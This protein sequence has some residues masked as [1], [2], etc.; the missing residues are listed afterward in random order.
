MPDTREPTLA[1]GMKLEKK[2]DNTGIPQS[3]MR[4]GEH[5]QRVVLTASAQIC[6]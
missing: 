3:G 4:K 1:I 2:E 5:S 6:K